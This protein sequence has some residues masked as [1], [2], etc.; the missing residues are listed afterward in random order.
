MKS[1]GN[2]IN[3]YLTNI[4]SS[5]RKKQDSLNLLFGGIENDKFFDKDEQ[6]QILF[7]STKSYQYA[8]SLDMPLQESDLGE[9]ILVDFDIKILNIDDK[10]Q[11]GTAIVQISMECPICGHLKKIDKTFPKLI[12]ED[13]GIFAKVIQEGTINKSDIVYKI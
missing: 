4:N 5:H 2:I 7:S 10:L 3:L 13:R 1:L 9:N 8:L 11:I 12:Q 6:R